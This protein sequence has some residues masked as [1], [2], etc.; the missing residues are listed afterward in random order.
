MPSLAKSCRSEHNSFLKWLQ[1]VCG[2]LGIKLIFV[3]QTFLSMVGMTSED[4]EMFWQL[5]RYKPTA[6]GCYGR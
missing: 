3:R 6:I 4:K 1:K 2:T 5:F